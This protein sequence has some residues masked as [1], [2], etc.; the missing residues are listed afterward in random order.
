[1]SDIEFIM[2]ALLIFF[3]CVYAAIIGQYTIGWF[4]LN[5]YSNSEILPSTNV[6]VIIPARN[7]ENNIQ[8]IL[9]DMVRQNYQAQYFEI[10][11]V[12]DNSSDSTAEITANFI[13]NHSDHRIRLIK[14]SDIHPH[15]AYKKKAIREAIEESTGDLIITTDADCRMNEKWLSSIVSFYELEKPK[16]IVGPVSFHNE[17]SYFE[18]M[19]TLEFLSLIAITA[20]AIRLGRPI[21]C[22]GAN[23]TY[24]KKSFYEV[25]GFDTDT[26]ASGDDV[27]LL[28]KIKKHFGSHSVRFMK[29]QDALVFTEAQKNLREFFHQRIRWASKNKVY[30]LNILLISFSVY[31]VNLLLI[32]GLFLSIFYHELL[33]TIL[34]A[35][36]IKLLIE[37]P[38]L[39]GIGNFVRRSRMFLFSFPLII[40]YPVYIIFTGAMGIVATYQ[41]KGRKV[42]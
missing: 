5:R 9:S 16:M 32:A 8:N 2:T 6:T 17:K 33:P 37:L 38:V 22:N 13:T 11:V 3:G 1:M 26:L 34:I 39:I 28:L 31:M 40:L 19:Q 24:E 35:F 7:E 41:W 10:I 30:D 15:G 25:G 42:R 18:K 12:D 29:N 36:F 21:M 4:R 20:G 14:I 27:F 23:L